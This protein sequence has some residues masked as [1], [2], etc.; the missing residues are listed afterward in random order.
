MPQADKTSIELDVLGEKL[1]VT[2]SEDPE[3]VQE[4]ALLVRSQI[5]ESRRRLSQKNAQPSK[6]N[7]LLL[8]LLELAEEYVK[9]KRRTALQRNKISVK[10]GEVRSLLDRAQGRG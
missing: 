6:Q 10:L 9:A 2:T 8:A 1:T 4:V 3:V 5:Q 7:I